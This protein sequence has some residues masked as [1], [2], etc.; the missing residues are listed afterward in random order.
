MDI[1]LD[2]R[3]CNKID[4]KTKDSVFGFVRKM[5]DILNIPGLIPIICLLFFFENDD[6]WDIEQTG[7]SL[8][9]LD[10]K[11]TISQGKIGQTA[12]FLTNILYHG[13]HKWKFRV[14]CLNETGSNGILGLFALHPKAIQSTKGRYNLSESVGMSLET[15][16]Y[17]KLMMLSEDYAIGCKSGDIVEMIADLEQGILKYI[18]NDIDYGKMC[19]IN[20]NEQEYVAAVCLYSLNDSLTLL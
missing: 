8:K 13:I 20:Q 4:S 11:K 2:F 5:E 10:D 15:G 6:E 9:I 18:I 16:K 14:N 3:K 1:E 17:N 12:A 19:D 7:K